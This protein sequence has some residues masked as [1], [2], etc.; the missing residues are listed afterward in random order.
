MGNLPLTINRSIIGYVIRILYGI[1]AIVLLFAGL[2]YTVYIMGSVPGAWLP[3]ILLYLILVG[4][5]T[6][7]SLYLYSLS[8]IDVTETGVR[9]QHW[10]SLFSDTEAN[11]AWTD[12]T[13]VSSDQRGILAELFGYGTLIIATADGLPDSRLT[14]VARADYWANLLNE[15]QA[16]TPVLTHNV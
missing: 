16:K 3:A 9:V 5:G 8:F 11:L 2:A 12:I 1:G 6:L 14:W 13:H 7:V 4:F 10:T 15:Q